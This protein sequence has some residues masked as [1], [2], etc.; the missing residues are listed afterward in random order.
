MSRM[1][2]VFKRKKK[3]ELSV[4]DQRLLERIDNLKEYVRQLQSDLNFGYITQREYE[5]RIAP[6]LSEITEMERARNIATPDEQANPT[7]WL[8]ELFNSEK[9]YDDK[10]HEQIEKVL[11]ECR[12]KQTEAD[13]KVL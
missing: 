11:D 10:V 8:D 5:V 3:S 12:S 13:K 2:K 1:I 6:I 4:D 7:S 9:Y